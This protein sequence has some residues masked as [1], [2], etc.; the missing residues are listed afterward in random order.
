MSQPLPNSPH[1]D[2]GGFHS[3]RSGPNPT[4]NELSAVVKY[5]VPHG[6]QVFAA[7]EPVRLRDALA[8]GIETV[9]RDIHGLQ[10]AARLELRP[11]AFD[12]NGSRRA[13]G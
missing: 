8:H 1:P 5:I 12:R 11:A 4:P 2:Q 9:G 13:G 7:P 6:F 3:T 10:A